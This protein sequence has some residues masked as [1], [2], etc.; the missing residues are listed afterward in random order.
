[1]REKMHINMYFFRLSETARKIMLR[2]YNDNI[3][4]VTEFSIEHRTFDLKKVYLY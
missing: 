3:Q 1:M 4:D 2:I